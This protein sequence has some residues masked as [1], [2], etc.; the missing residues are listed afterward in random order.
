[1]LVTVLFVAAAVVG[2]TYTDSKVTPNANEAGDD[3]ASFD[4]LRT[5]LRSKYPDKRRRAVTALAALGT[6]KAKELVLDALEDPSSEVADEAQLVLVKFESLGIVQDL[7]GKHGLRSKDRWV[8]LRVAEA[9]GRFQGPIDAWDIVR[10]F[11]RREPEI[12][13][14]SLWSIERLARRGALSDDNERVVKRL[15]LLMTRKADDTV[16]AAALQVLV[17][18]D[19]RKGR[20]AVETLRDAKGRETACSVLLALK[21]LGA[22]EYLGVVERATA[23]AD[24]AVRAMAIGLLE[25]S[26]ARSSLGV[27]VERLRVEERPVLRERLVA[28]LRWLTGFRHGDRVDAWSHTVSSLPADWDPK[29]VRNAYREQ[30][31]ATGSMA[32]LRRLD[33]RSDRLAILVDFSGSLWTERKDGTRRKDLLDPEIEALLARLN[34]KGCFFLVPYTRVPHPM[35]KAPIK[36]SGLNVRKA[37]SFFRDAR[38]NGQGNIYDA[39][40][41]ALSFEDIDRILILTDGAPTGG[42]RWNVDLMVPLLLEKTRFRPV[43]FDFVLLDAPPRLERRWR[44]LA[45]KTGGRA[46]PLRF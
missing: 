3:A 28:A 9:F 23:A 40:E 10:T 6:E 18:L 38:M 15:G 12:V 7:L 31:R 27:L 14:A 37:Q 25:G 29:D 22:P 39:I 41:L 32:E 46:I 24:P 35:T 21:E 30:S 45:E 26:A 16:R 43:V 34:Q 20:L 8:R 11:D 13:R 36:A 1:M 42:R 19:P 5:K 2:P 33:P 17:Q 4:D 44:R